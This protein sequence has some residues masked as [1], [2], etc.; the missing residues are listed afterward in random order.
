MYVGGAP[1]Q[2][3]DFLTSVYGS[4]VW[5]ILVVAALAY[6]VLLWA[7]RSLLLPLMAM[8]LDALS[9]AASCG[10]LVVVFRFG[11]GRSAGALPRLTD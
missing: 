10:M 9:V 1:A 6:I 2:G 3:A 8:L 7:F 11:G 4:F 5:V